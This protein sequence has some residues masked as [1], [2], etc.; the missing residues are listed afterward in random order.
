MCVYNTCDDNMF[1]AIARAKEELISATNIEDSPDEMAVIDSV[2]FRFW[3]MG[4]LDAKDKVR[5]LKE[6]NE[7][8]RKLVMYMHRCYVRGHDWGPFGAPEKAFVEQCMRE[9]GIEADDE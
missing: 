2:L 4:W 5:S 7:K 8:L 9:L 1:E 6:E 3:Q